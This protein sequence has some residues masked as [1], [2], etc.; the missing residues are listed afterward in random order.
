[1]EGKNLQKSDE[2]AIFCIIV[3]ILVWVFDATLMPLIYANRSNV[4]VN[5]SN[6]SDNSDLLQSIN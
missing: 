1:M 4:K 2:G 5:N 6:N 3:G